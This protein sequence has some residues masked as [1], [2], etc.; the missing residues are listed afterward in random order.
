MVNQKKKDQLIRTDPTQI[1]HKLLVNILRY[2]NA[3][4]EL[5]CDLLT[6]EI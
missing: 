3:I 4:T 5:H 6:L 2:T 1:Q